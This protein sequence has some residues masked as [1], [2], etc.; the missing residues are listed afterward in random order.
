MAPEDAPSAS[1]QHAEVT[2]TDRQRP[3]TVSKAPVC[4]APGAVDAA[5]S[6]LDA[7]LGHNLQ[8]LLVEGD[9]L[10]QEREQWRLD[11]RRAKTA[12]VTLRM[13]A[14]GFGCNNPG[15]GSG[16]KNLF[17]A[18]PKAS[19]HD[20]DCVAEHGPPQVLQRPATDAQR[21]H[22]NDVLVLKLQDSALV[23][24]EV[25]HSRALAR[26]LAGAVEHWARMDPAALPLPAMAGIESLRNEVVQSCIARQGRQDNETERLTQEQAARLVPV[27][28]AALAHHAGDVASGLEQ[29][30]SASSLA[31]ETERLFPS[32]LL[33]ARALA[34]P[35]IA[36]RLAAEGRRVASLDRQA[37]PDADARRAQQ[38]RWW[39][40]NSPA[41]LE[42]R[43]YRKNME[44]NA[45]PTADEMLELVRHY[46][47]LDRGR[48]ADRFYFRKDNGRFEARMPLPLVGLT[49]LYDGAISLVNWR[50]QPRQGAQWCE[51]TYSET[52]LVATGMWPKPPPDIVRRH[53]AEFRWT[54]SG[55]ES[56]GLQ[57]A[58][59]DAHASWNAKVDAI[60]D[61]RSTEQLQR[62]ACISR[63]TVLGSERQ[64]RRNIDRHCG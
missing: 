16:L 58:I 30:G 35:A 24:R 4:V 8:Q 50:C 3:L 62:D 48:G 49:T 54:E 31:L 28:D 1:R 51:L 10:A 57:K 29:A 61:K 64:T 20:V 7:G 5:A 44:T 43:R 46:V 60:R 55:L 22:V 33:K 37:R 40:E 56:A 11:V 42:R 38:E 39:S 14:P 26:W 18:D 36:K 6:V 9:R 23:P 27:F 34:Q 45:A 15:L 21:A 53:A 32:P 2:V 47:I 41:A 59:Q 52:T 63:N 17:R 19:F 25:Q 13:P 12:S